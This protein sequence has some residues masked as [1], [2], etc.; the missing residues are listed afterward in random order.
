MAYQ[1]WVIPVYKG[2]D[3]R[4][5]GMIITGFGMEGERGL[6]EVCLDFPS[7]TKSC[8]YL[9]DGTAIVRTPAERGWEPPAGWV[10]TTEDAVTAKIDL[11]GLRSR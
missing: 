6:T 11:V 10:A 4:F 2:P 7:G 5:P 3:T 1:W 8:G 9:E